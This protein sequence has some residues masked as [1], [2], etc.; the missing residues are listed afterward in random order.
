MRG[1]VQLPCPVPWRLSSADERIRLILVDDDDD[2]REAVSGELADLGFAVQCFADGASMLAS[3]A[4]GT[5]ADIIVLDWG[6]PALSGIDLLPRLR[7]EGIQLPVV[8]LTGRTSPNHEHL[9]FDRGALDFVDKARGVPI[10]AKRIKV[11]VE[12]SKRPAGAR[13]RGGPA[14]RPADAE[15]PGQPRLLG[16]GGHQ[17][18]PDR[19]QHRAPARFEC[20]QS[21]DVSRSLRLHASR[22]LHRREWREWLPN[23]CPF[24]H[25]A[26]SKQVPTRR[27]E[28]AEIENYPSF[29]YRWGKPKDDAA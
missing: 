14:L 22:R 11:I 18:D 6:L 28:F 29:G 3:V 13:G 12:S 26:H 16:R 25:Q 9:A 5:N 1:P 7:R 8:F 21:R 23:Q 17:P 24:I 4:D 10:L 27:S 19:V 20:R 2:F 15:A